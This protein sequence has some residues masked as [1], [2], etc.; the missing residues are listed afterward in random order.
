MLAGR[1]SRGSPAQGGLSVVLIDNYDSFTYN[2]YQYLA[3]VTSDVQVFRNDA[4]EVDELAAL[5][6]DAIVISPGPKAPKDAGISK[7]IIRRLGPIYPTLGVCL[8]HQCINEVFGGQTVRAPWPWHG[9]T[10]II[11]HDGDALFASLPQGIEVARYHSL[12]ADARTVSGCL[13]VTAWTDDG[14]IMG[15]RHRDLP[16]EGVQF[17]PESFMTQHGHEMIRNFFTRVVGREAGAARVGVLHDR[18]G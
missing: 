17:H 15:L 4:I 14:L 7:E 12:V 11:R 6:P 1:S 3:L 5:E 9:K 16:I 10:S 2:L 8:G 13:K 18:R